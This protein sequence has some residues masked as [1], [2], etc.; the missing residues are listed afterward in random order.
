MLDSMTL[1]AIQ[2]VMQTS[3]G[4]LKQANHT[5][6]LLE[7]LLY[8]ATTIAVVK[9]VLQRLPVDGIA[10]NS[11]REALTKRQMQSLQPLPHAFQNPVNSIFL[12]HGDRDW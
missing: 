10:S 2:R 1:T 9:F 4:D 8:D 11:M 7:R 6:I 5:D 3:I 12:H